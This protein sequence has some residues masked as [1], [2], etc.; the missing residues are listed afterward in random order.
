MSPHPA[1]ERAEDFASFPVL[2]KRMQSSP[3][4]DG[5]LAE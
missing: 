3:V 1:F 2:L 4:Q 5:R